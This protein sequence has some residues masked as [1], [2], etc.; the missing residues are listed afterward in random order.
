MDLTKKRPLLVVLVTIFLDM[1]GYGILIPIIPVL[2]GDPTSKDFILPAYFT[3]NQGY[4]MLGILLGSQSLVQFFAAPILG[5]LSDKYGRKKV[6]LVSLAGTA[7]SYVIFAIGIMTKNIPLLFISRI[8]DGVT[9][10][11]IS[12]AQAAVADI[13]S[14]ANRTKNFALMGAAFGL[15]FIIGPFIGGQL[16]D[17]TAVFWFN[18]ATPFWFS[19]ILSMAA[20]FLVVFFFDETHKSQDENLEVE[21][22]QSLGHIEKAY[23][24]P[25]L[26]SVF[27]SSFMYYSGFS[28]FTTF[29][30]I[31]LINR[32]QFNQ[33]DIGAFFAYVGI[34]FIITQVII[35]RYFLRDADEKYVLPFSFLLAGIGVFSLFAVHSTFSLCIIIPIFAM[36]NGITMVNI[37]SLISKSASKDVQGEILGI[38]ASVQAVAQAIPPILSGFIAAGLTAESPLF[39]SG[40]L[41]VLASI[42]FIF[43]YRTKLKAGA[44]GLFTQA[45]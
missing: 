34:W 3:L 32:L 31:F 17:P 22:N 39:I 29:F 20:F 28:F 21:W 30:S 2:L 12:V 18:A 43:F 42:I 36:A 24:T 33:G 15:G 5:Q 38:G 26:R 7:L 1:L 4:I 41:M 19:V 13:S 9:G 40:S 45:D 8:L 35:I 6:L 11:N 23:T 27:T 16:S 25:S 10:G 14:R 44:K 37:T